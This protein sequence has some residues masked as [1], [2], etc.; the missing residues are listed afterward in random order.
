MAKKINRMRNRAT[1][2]ALF[3]ALAFAAPSTLVAQDSES[4]DDDWGDEEKTGLQWHGFVET[5]AGFRLQNDPVLNGKETTLG[6]FRL[7]LETSYGLGN[8]ALSLKADGWY[9][10]VTS[11]LRT[12]IR[13]LTVSVALSSAIDLKLGRQVLTWGTGDY[14]F[15]ND[16][17]SKNWQGFFAGQANEY[18]KAASNSIKASWYKDAVSLNVVWTPI[19]APDTYINGE[20]FSFFSPQLGQNVAPSFT[21]VEPDKGLFRGEF[22]ARL[23]VQKGSTE[24]A[25]Y[26]YRG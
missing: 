15:I 4:W 3:L 1:Y 24:Y 2:S 12:N 6:D 10:G 9:D 22:A 5:A 19:F 21:A 23:K 14:L 17:F 26:G 16:Q 18:L 8:A 11:K 13:D 7:R 20:R 25:F